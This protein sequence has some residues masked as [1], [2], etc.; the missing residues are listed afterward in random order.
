MS[1]PLD[2]YTLKNYLLKQNG[3]LFRFDWKCNVVT[4]SCTKKTKMSSN[5]FCSLIKW[6]TK[7]SYAAE[8]QLFDL[9]VVRC[10]IQYM[11]LIVLNVPLALDITIVKMFY[12]VPYVPVTMKL[13]P[14]GQ[15][16][17]NVRQNADEWFVQKLFL[18]KI[19]ALKRVRRLSDQHCYLYNTSNW[20]L[21]SK[22]D[23]L[24]ENI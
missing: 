17:V 6:V 10:I 12:H 9:T 7:I 24:V 22:T 3:G 21:K 13:P 11:C 15:V 1:E 16:Y 4:V 19:Q 14:A 2:A 20:H 5:R 18:F 23:R 8:K